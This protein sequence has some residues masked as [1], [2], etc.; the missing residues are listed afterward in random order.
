MPFILSH[1]SS[2]QHDTGDHPEQPARM[3]AIARELDAH[4]WFGWERLESQPV[5]RTLLERVHPAG[6]IDRLERIC[7]SGGGMLDIDTVVSRGSFG[8]ALHAAGGAAALVQRLIAEGPGTVGFSLHRPPGHHA[9]ADRAMG[10][11]LF[12]NVA[13]AATC[14]LETFGLERVLILDWDVH[15][16]NGTQDIFWRSD[17]V[18]FASLHQMPLYPGSGA[19]AETGA[20]A[21]AGF[22]LNLPV[23]AGSGDEVWLGLINERVVPRLREWRP[24]LV[25]VSAGFDA[26][27]DDPLAG[28]EVSTEGFASMASVVRAA[29]TSVGAP[30]GLVLEGGYSLTALPRSVAAV[31]EALT[32]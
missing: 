3:T 22:T 16:G 19:A 21:G 6:H 26:H 7:R 15:H 27:R 4:D 28:C 11:C 29:A 5:E 9:P 20:G 32:D 1:P 13:V 23:A 14:A 17:R 31:M 8:A 10:F 30:L 25:L 18:L 12:N 2:L 24:Q